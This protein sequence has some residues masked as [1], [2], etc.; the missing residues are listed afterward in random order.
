MPP[1]CVDPSAAARRLRPLRI[2]CCSLLHPLHLQLP[3]CVRF[4]LAKLLLHA[5]RL[6]PLQLLLPIASASAAVRPLRLLLSAS[7][8]SPSWIPAHCSSRS[9]RFSKKVW[10]LRAKCSLKCVL[11]GDS[12]LYSSVLLWIQSSCPSKLY[13]GYP[14]STRVVLM[15]CGS[16]E[17]VRY[18]SD[19]ILWFKIVSSLCEAASMC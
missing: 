1:D 9:S 12:C 10:Y 13:V 15:S 8:C 11:E 19:F 5:S 17:L 6:R 16:H 7:A 18:V 14:H 4:Q 3:V 2:S